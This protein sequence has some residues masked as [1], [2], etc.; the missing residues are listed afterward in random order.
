MRQVVIVAPQFPPGNLTGG[1]RCRYFAMHLPKF[2]W[3]VKVLTVK[4][5]YYEEK[6]DY[7]LEKLLPP[8]LEV[9]RTKAFPIRPIRLIGDIGI[10]ALWWHYR[11]LCSLI[12]KEKVDLIYIPI[13]PNYSAMLGPLIYRRFGIPYAI[14]YMDPWVHTWPGCEKLFSKAWFSY[15]LAKILEP[16]VLRNISLITG[17]APGYY[18]GVLKRYPWLGVS[19][20]FALPYGAEEADF[21]YLDKHPRPPYLFNPCDGG[22]HIVYAG[23]MLP[24]AYSTLEA[25]F[26]AIIIFK[27][28]YPY[29]VQKLKFHFIGTGS[30]PIDPKSF[31]V[32]PY[33]KRYNLLDTIFENPARI[34]YLDVLNHLKYSNAVLL[35][36]SSEPHYTPSKVFQAVLSLRPVIALLHAKSTAVG[37]LKET[38][39]GIVVSFDEEMPVEKRIDEI[40]QAI[41]QALNYNY[42]QEAINWDAFR[43]Y[44]AEAMAQRLAKAFNLC[45]NSR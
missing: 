13:P 3:K 41:Y 12:R 9:I 23:A 17:V 37:I 39:A 19:R 8:D 4:P 18:E 11:T 6:L 1:H 24:R 26:K 25:L 5:S 31:T 2:G 10:R 16:I 42:S 33:A 40:V 45:L 30:N 28:D 15:H 34:P 20:R 22:F 14:D 44:S 21:Q 27:K 35:L 43:A 32:K 29:F 7:E 38:N 36:G